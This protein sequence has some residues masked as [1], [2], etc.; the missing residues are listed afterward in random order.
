MRDSYGK[1]VYRACDKAFP[2]PALLGRQADESIK[3]WKL[4]LTASDKAAIAK[5][6]SDHRWAP[7]QLRHTF[8]TEVR[9]DHGLESAQVLL[10][11]SKADTTQI[12]AERDRQLASKVAM[13]MG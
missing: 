4:R 5:W 8:A 12:Y 2:P 1:A 7:N 3:Q 13:L 9:R 6:Q 10:G 11:H